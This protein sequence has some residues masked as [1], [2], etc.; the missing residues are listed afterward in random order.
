MAAGAVTRAAGALEYGCGYVWTTAQTYIVSE[1][2]TIHARRADDVMKQ[3]FEVLFGSAIVI[4]LFMAPL[5]FPCA[6]AGGYWAYDKQIT[7]LTGES[8]FQL[9]G[10][11][12]HELSNVVCLV[13]A[14]MLHFLFG[15]E[16]YITIAF[17]VGCAIKRM[18]LLA[19]GPAPLLVIP[20]PRP[21]VADAAAQAGAPGILP[22]VRA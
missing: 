9:S 22:E 20:A 4:S 15:V 2:V 1:P 16:I 21:P 3:H 18:M 7:N 10:P 13:V 14:V 19:T 5:A 12:N 8:L 17:L 11:L 6:A